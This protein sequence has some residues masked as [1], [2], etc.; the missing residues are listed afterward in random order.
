MSVDHTCGNP[1]SVIFYGAEEDRV[2]RLRWLVQIK[3]PNIGPIMQSCEYMYF[4]ILVGLI[5]KRSLH[6]IILFFSRS[7]QL[8]G[9]Q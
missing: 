7:S 5:W 9:K 1:R 3:R 2:A 6:T 4:E 8:T